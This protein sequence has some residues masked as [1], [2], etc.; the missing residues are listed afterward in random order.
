M[1]PVRSWKLIFSKQF[2]RLNLFGV[3]GIIRFIFD[4]GETSSCT[5][6]KSGFFGSKMK[7]NP[8]KLKG[9]SEV[10]KIEGIGTVE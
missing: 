10:L 8:K 3:S 5:P 7:I 2:A 4:M 9:I 1:F 6:R